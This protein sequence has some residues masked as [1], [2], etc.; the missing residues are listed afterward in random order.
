[1][2]DE[3]KGTGTSPTETPRPRASSRRRLGRRRVRRYTKRAI[4]VAV[5]LVAA[6]LVSFVTIDLGPVV[7]A[8]AAA[9]ASAQLER[10]VEIGRLGTYILP[11]R[12]L[13]ED[14]VISGLEPGD[15]PFFHADRIVISIS[16]FALLR[17]E[18]LVDEV[19]MHGWRML[20]ESFP[21][22]RHSFPDFDGPDDDSGADDGAS[23]EIGTGSELE[24]DLE[25]GRRIVTTVQYLR[26]HDG[27]FVYEDPGAPWSVAARNIDLTISKINEY[28]GQAS[29]HDGTV[30][31]GDFE[32]M[33]VAMDATY[34]LDGSK[35]HLS[36]IDLTMDGFES[37]LDGDVDLGN[38]PEQ[39][40]RI[41]EST[42]D[43]PTMKDIFFADD[44]FTIT[45]GSRFVGE[46]HI[47][48][49]GR[50]LTG[51]FKSESAT[52][53]DLAFP[54]VEG[55]VV[56][57]AD[58][59]EVFDYRSGFYGGELQ[60]TY[61]MAP[62]GQ[63]THGAHTLAADL[64][65]VALADLFTA[66]EVR[67]VRPDGRVSGTTRLG[68]SMGGGGFAA[69]E[70][71]GR[72]EIT[73]PD[74]TRLAVPRRPMAVRPA[75]AYAATPFDPEG[76]PWPFPLGGEVAFELG[77]EWI[78]VAPSHLA[79]PLTVIEFEGR[80]AYG[81][82]SRLPFH[83]T[84]LDW[85]ESDR[86]M[87]AILTAQG[88]P[89]NEV[90]V[91]GRGEFDGVV[92]DEFSAPRIE[93]SFDGQGITAWDVAWGVGRGAITIEN[94]YVDVVDG[95]FDDG[96]ASLAVDGRFSLGFPRDDGGEEIN[97]RIRL[98]DLPSPRLRRAFD[99]EGYEI[100]GP[101]TGTLE[102][103]GEYRRLFG[104]GRLE[105]GETLAYGE[106]FD[107]VT[108]VLQFE[109]DGVRVA[110]LEA[111]KGRGR[112][113]G[114]AFIRWD[115]TYSLN[116][117]GRGLS[118]DTIDAVVDERLPLGGTLQFSVSGSG[119]F[120][121]PRYDLNATVTDLSMSGEV[122]G[123]VTGRVEVRRG[124]L[125]VVVEAASPRLAVSGS[126]Q[127]ELTAEAEAQLQFR[128]TN[129][130]LDPYIRA[131]QPDL[132]LPAETTAVVSGILRVN[133]PV[134]E[135]DRLVVDA[136]IEQADLMFYDYAVGNDGPIR[137]ALDQ[138]VVRVERLRLTG[139]GTALALTGQ[140]GLSDERVA[141]HAEG[142]ASL[143]ILQGFFPD[144]RSS[145][146]ARLVADIGG[147][148]RVPVIVGEA[149]LE[150]GRLR[151]FSLPHAL[152][153]IGGRLVFEPGG[154][155]FDDLT[156]EL[157]GGPVRFG[158]RIGLTGYELGALS[159]TAVGTEMSWRYPEDVRSLVDADLTLRRDTSGLLVAGTIN[160]RDAVWLELFDQTSTGLINFTADD[161]LEARPTPAAL[162]LRFDIRIV[163]PS[164]LRI[165]DR[166]AQIVLS[167][168]LTLGGSYDHPLLFGNAEVERG[169]VFF[170][171]NRYR[172]TRGSISFA[173][174]NEI[175]PFF[176]IE[177][178]TDVR[179]PGQTYRVTLGL[180]GSVDQ[181]G[182]ELSSDPPLQQAQI[183]AMLLGDRRD[184]QQAELRTLRARE[185][186]QQELFQAGAARLLTSPL[187]SGV[188][189]VM[190]DSFGVDT[191]EITPGLDGLSAQQSSQLVPT[192]RV[193]IGKRI[194]DRAYVAFSR[195]LSGT[196]RDLLVVL[197]YDQSDRLSW[198]F[199]QNEDRTYA[200]D[201]RVR[202][203]F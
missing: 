57:T 91:G 126:G 155:V 116:A 12:F 27:E 110:G 41:L 38:W 53:N 16:W 179:V 187:S 136:T 122:V 125:G 183:F 148:F 149:A 35:V 79:T 159:L 151:H 10:E 132:E 68:W 131:F 108:A 157:G 172:V 113:T 197:E 154:I 88:A 1:M 124:V 14:V 77:S 95:T 167:A 123:Q 138:N 81:A 170:E 72:L 128:F 90:A 181:L 97:A 162:P 199:S 98:R 115:G 44:E 165:S 36:R 173:N 46:W 63:P 161:T 52:L 21:D 42:I 92:L 150:D 188:G 69:L 120:A 75:A 30:K 105:L 15:R 156:G 48:E 106:P 109:G 5:A 147:T 171:G 73:P 54:E 196:S 112:V 71:E 100:N 13:I 59:F 153:A 86:L 146:D 17:G 142:D 29:F 61:G 107:S 198:I 166:N 50:E 9:A 177:A 202:H 193:L 83:V 168:E 40:Y 140:V 4:I 60:L 93:A 55:A 180:S 129:T 143:G 31:I 192:A 65:A 178:E 145:G 74:G 20:V 200:L 111:R 82:R 114:A 175:E 201:F 164:S 24:A 133:G 144:I 62:L 84:S 103:S 94:S 141:L 89:A 64:T 174:P 169:Q 163:A 99:L 58:R 56:W 152:E 158:G 102:L 176:D 117:D 76:G 195:T 32:P 104:S 127:I 18:I 3:A 34:T 160:V 203:A 11:G 26:A 135:L 185:A 19:D 47:F 2:T 186:S 39:T 45:G 189:R 49:G 139:K 191:F 184:P 137:L 67:G 96:A 23:V 8:R 33:T 190:E 28:G 134:R 80:T 7:R 118:L 6:A 25:T 43:L 130:A 194:S 51:R 119:A 66:L 121:D 78:E 101:I 37:V 182:F 87:A 70:G 22:G 85:Q